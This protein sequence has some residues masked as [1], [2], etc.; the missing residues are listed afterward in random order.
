MAKK[1]EKKDQVCCST[2]E[3]V[4]Q[5]CHFKKSH[6]EKLCNVNRFSPVCMQLIAFCIWL[7]IESDSQSCTDIKL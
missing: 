7:Y 2:K 5:L 3:Q 4:Q 1:K 6:L